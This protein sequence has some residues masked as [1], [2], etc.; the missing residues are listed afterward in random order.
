[1]EG[2]RAERPVHMGRLHRRP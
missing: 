2:G 1:M